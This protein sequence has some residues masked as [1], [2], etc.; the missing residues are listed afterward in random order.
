MAKNGTIRKQIKTGWAA[1]ISWA[2]DS[3][4]VSK[5]T[6]KMTVKVQLISEGSSYT[7]NSS[8]EKKGTLKI[9]GSTYSFTFSAA[10]SGN[11]TKTIYTKTVDIAHS[12][13]GSKSVSI[14][15][16]IGLNVTL[17]GSSITNVTMS[18]TAALDT[19]P[20][21][22]TI[23]LSHSKVVLGSTQLTVNI[24]RKSSN[25]THKIYY[26]LGSLNWCGSSNATTSFSFTPALSDAQ[27]IPNSMKSWATIVCDTYNGNTKIGS[28][29]ATFDVE[30]PS[31]V[32]PSF[33]SLSAAVVADGADT[34][35]GYVK[36]K[37]KCKLTINSAA[38][39]HGSTIKSYH[40]SGGG[41]TSTAS[42]F[43]T[44]RLN[45]S[46]NIT[47]TAY[48]TDSRG[49]KSDTKTVTINVQDYVAPN[50]TKFSVE[51][52]L[53]NGAADKTG[54]YLKISPTYTYSSLGG[55]N[56]ITSKAEFKQSTATTWTNAGAVNSGGSLVTGS[57][58]IHTDKS[59]DVRVTITDRF[60]STTKQTKVPT[61]YATI[62]IK[63][64]GKGIGI[65]KYAEKDNLLD[66]GMNTRINGEIELGTDYLS[67]MGSNEN[68]LWFTNTTSNKSLQMRNTGALEYN[69]EPVLVLSKVNNSSFW[70]LNTGNKNESNWIR[71]TSNGLIPYKENSQNGG[72]HG[73]SQLGTA[74]W[75]WQNIYTHDFNVNGAISFN[76][77]QSEKNI[78]LYNSNATSGTT[79]RAYHKC[80]FY[81]GNANSIVAIGTYDAQH[82]HAIWTY[83]DG[84]NPD[85]TTG[86]KQMVVD[87]NVTFSATG[88][89]SS[90]DERLK[91]DFKNLERYEDF[92][93]K[94][95]PISFKYNNG[96]SGRDWVGV[97]AQQVEKALHESG[98]TNLDFAGIVINQKFKDDDGWNGFEEEYG[99][100]YEQFI[101]L[102][103][104]MI[105]KLKKEIDELKTEIKQL[106]EAKDASFFN[107]KF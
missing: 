7:I 26:K 19:I 13:D 29:S 59:F 78:F 1:Q 24:S 96:E 30:I 61:A 100:R 58:G 38:G 44:S 103:T 82:G 12:S 92:F 41:Q 81:G 85:G 99:I 51:R 52:C 32:K 25:F 33:S 23:S 107:K 83:R 22:S 48:V 74:T 50:I 62:D 80:K 45:T 89:V 2:V 57:N 72:T 18:G 76:A 20:R 9:N 66:V 47:F 42:S 3:Q 46:G 94:I 63:R 70:G 55:K 102:N 14:E 4:D 40:I 27:Y 87:G 77:N 5:N 97:S 10:L 88:T 54:T 101:M 90:S 37:S 75:R 11:Q 6:S 104:H 67:K 98:L 35:Y 39:I 86:K 71:T 60:G 93:Y 65:G 34:S 73:G 43:T 16:T 28:A 95:E 105:Q 69:S 36:G 84:K 21:A 49:Q 79:N 15:S 17:S 56:T 91:H 53:S 68:D 8:A 64:G 31:S 106:R